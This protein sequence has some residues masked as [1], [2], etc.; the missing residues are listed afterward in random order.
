VVA[1]FFFRVLDFV[2]RVFGLLLVIDVDV[3]ETFAAGDEKSKDF[4]V[5]LKFSGVLS[6]FHV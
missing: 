5:I 2:E 1:R 3:G 6:G 4:G